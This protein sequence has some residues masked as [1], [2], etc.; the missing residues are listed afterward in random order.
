M[1][2]DAICLGAVTEELNH[3]LAGCRVEKVY[4]PDRD[5][6]V[7]QTRGQGGARRLLVSTAAG[8]PRVHFIDVARENPAAPPMFC[9]LLRKHVQ[10]AKIAAVVQPAVERMLTI[11]LDTTDEMG[12]ACKKH[13][14]CELMGKH[15][16]VILCGED[17]R[18]IDAM[19]RVDGD[20]SG[21]RQVLPGLFYRLPP[22]QEK[23]DPF[24]LSGVGLSAS[25]QSADGEMGL[26]R[27]LLS[28]LLGF[29]PL[30]CR[31][32]SYRATGDT[33]KPVGKLTAEEQLRLAQVF[34]DLK[35]YLT[36]KRWKPFL[37]TKT[38]DHAV[39][40]FS[41]LPITQY[42]GLMTVS[43]EQ[44]FSDLLAA[45]FEKKGKAERM[46]RRS[47]DLHKA[48]V[49]ARDRLARKL[50]AQQK[51]LDATQNREQ[52]K[53]LG[54]L[55]T[56]NLYQLEKGMNK[57]VVV[58]Y[59]DEAC[60]EVEVALDVRLTPQQNAQK[61]F[62]LYNKAKTAEEVLTQQLAQG[63]A[64]LDYLESVLVALGEAESE[65]DLAQLREE[66]TQAGV[67]SSKQARNKK[68]RV[69]PVAAKPFHYRSSDGFDIFAGKNNLQNDL[70][71]LKTAF[72]S[73]IWFHTQKIHGSHVILVA[74]GREPT[75]RAM[76]EAAMIAAYHSKARQSSLVPV[77][78]TPVRQVKKPAGAKPGMV[79]YHVYQTAY[80]T[81]DEAAVERLRI[82]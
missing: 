20:L 3:V 11:E 28:Q 51:E 61:Y 50:A 40:D 13:L 64:D 6:I 59:Y 69:K 35:S 70:L 1:P 38:E 54:D 29:S 46:A 43:Q 9:M 81:P 26:D 48:V 80:V 2:L 15:S 68:Q 82:E 36:E 74:D 14:I 47:A 32:L 71:T 75:D 55:I 34:E 56:A 49:N 60:P 45:F 63:R 19:R 17:N 39:F 53:R 22:A 5:E 73:D 18:I 62:K 33:A 10:G 65:R 44:S 67:L 4:Q 27:Y 41:F 30:L 79:I 58:D 25:L 8:A 66:L 42:E 24:A 52:Y 77:D 31:E 21:K 37:L 16:N 78:Y 12:V 76:T 7:L 57:A 23:H 72:K